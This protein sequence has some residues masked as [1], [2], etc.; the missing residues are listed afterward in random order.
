[1][2]AQHQGTSI[3]VAV[4]ALQQGGI[5]A[6]PTE[7][8]YGLGCDPEN[9][10]AIERLLSIKQRDKEKG[11]ILIAASFEQLTPY[12]LELDNDT[13]QRVLPGWP[14]ATTWLLPAKPGTSRLLRGNHQNIAVRIT[15]HPV[16]KQLCE[17]W[18]G[19]LISTSA[20]IRTQN[21]AR[22]SKDVIDIF[23]SQLDY[24]LDGEVGK[25]H[26]ATQ[27]KDGQTGQ[28]IRN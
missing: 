27:I 11:L 5:I 18:Q 21:A 25:L 1:M 24:I 23:G 14:G 2:N 9:N 26:Q 19:A 10:Q 17:Q 16:A 3:E 6:Y 12:L 4:E 15:D 28:I 20:N 22:S 7:A 8:V 13:R